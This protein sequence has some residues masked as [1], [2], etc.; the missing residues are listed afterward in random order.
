[1]NVTLIIDYLT[2]LEKENKELNINNKE[3][4]INNTKLVEE[5]ANLSKFSILTN[6]NKQ[7]EK[8][9]KM[10]TDLNNELR[11][12]KNNITIVK[13]QLDKIIMDLNNELK[14][15]NDNI[16]TLNDD[17]NILKEQLE[18]TNK[19]NINLSNE[20]K[21]KNIYIYNLE[22]QVETNTNNYEKII[23]KDVNYLLDP[24][25]NIYDIVNNKPNN[26][27]AVMKNNKVKFI[28]K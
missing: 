12:N 22:N 10:N 1:M 5:L 11:N 19:I 24:D 26:K 7:L 2:N 14:I 8:T 20:L 23:I 18:K 21:E 17:I 3:L 27:V 25:N 13:Q 15:K 9:N 4:N 16:N 6:V 28:K